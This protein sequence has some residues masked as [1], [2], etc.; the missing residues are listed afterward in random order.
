MVSVSVGARG[1]LNSV[2][3]NFS[4]KRNCSVLIHNHPSG[5]IN[6]SIKDEILTEKV[7]ELGNSMNIPLIDHIIIGSNGYYSLITKKSFIEE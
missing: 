1:S 6:P 3:V 2:P 4:Q 5:N 7:S